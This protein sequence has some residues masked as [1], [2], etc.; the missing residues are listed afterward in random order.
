MVATDGD[1]GRGNRGLNFLDL[2]LLQCEFPFDTDVGGG[3]LG[4]GELILLAFLHYQG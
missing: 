3:E 1:S 4:G 2:S